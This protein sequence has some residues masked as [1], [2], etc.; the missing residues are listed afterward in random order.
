MRLLLILLS[1]LTCNF[2]F[3]QEVEKINVPKHVTYNYCKHATVEKAKQKIKACLNNK[4]EY[5][6]A[7][8]MLIIGPNLWTRFKDIKEV[9]SIEAG[10]VEFHIDNEVVPGKMSQDIEDTKKIWDVLREEVNGSYKIRKA[11]EHELRY[12]WSVISF[13][14]DE[15]LLIVETKDHNYI[16]DF[17]EEDLKLM[18]LDEAP[19]VNKGPKTYRNGKEVTSTP[20]GNKETKL[21]KVI[22][23]SSDEDLKANSS[24]E[25]ISLIIKEVSEV[26]TDLFKNSKKSGKIFVEFELKKKKNEIVYLIKDDVDLD[27]MTQFEKKINQLKLPKSKKEPVKFQLMYKINSFN[28]TE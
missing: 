24:V 15:P 21:E 4:K 23:L 16:L 9:N 7:Q 17:V 10:K 27:I 5:S 8:S 13:D 26:F 12:Y 22:L 11:N 2:C 25:D 20:K 18:W 3:A 6:V 14:I 28:D 19:K 1:L